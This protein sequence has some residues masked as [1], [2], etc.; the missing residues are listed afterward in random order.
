LGYIRRN[1][2]SI[3]LSNIVY[4]SDGCPTPTHRGPTFRSE[5][6]VK[7][8]V[9]VVLNG[10]D[11][12]RLHLKLRASLEGHFNAADFTYNPGDVSYMYTT[13]EGTG[14]RRA[15]A[16]VSEGHPEWL[17]NSCKWYDDVS[18]F[19]VRP[20]P[21]L[22]TDDASYQKKARRTTA[23]FCI[24]KRKIAP[25]ERIVRQFEAHVKSRDEN[26]VIH[27]VSVG[28]APYEWDAVY[29]LQQSQRKYSEFRNVVFK[30]VKFLTKPDVSDLAAQLELL[31]GQFSFLDTI[32][33]AT[34]EQFPETGLNFRLR[35]AARRGEDGGN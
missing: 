16:V 2:L 33:H 15:V 35:F 32:E 7:V 3:D 4:E 22:G 6:T 21:F 13:Q 27:V 14:A 28:D 31:Q 1:D 11:L 18:P 20:I 9:D 24:R 25:F 17:K 29:E 8:Y 30:K 26:A 5:Y 10:D 23:E 34:P 19:P 12:R